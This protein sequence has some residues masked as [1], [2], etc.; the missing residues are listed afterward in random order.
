L[1]KTIQILCFAF[2]IHILFG[3]FTSAYAEEAL[4][5][6]GK[7]QV[8]LVSAYYSPLPNQE[9]YV[10][11]SYEA[12]IRLNGK[13][14]AGADG[15]PVYV[16]MLAAP[17]S[18]PFGTQI[19]IPGLGIGTVHDR[20][21]A[22]LELGN[23]HR[24]DVWMG[25]GDDGR[26]RALS[27]GMRTV[28][29]KIY[30]AGT[31]SG[32]T[33]AFENFTPPS[34]PPPSS[35]PSS[36]IVQSLSLGSTGEAVQKLQTMLSDIGIYN[37][38]ISG[39]FDK[40]TQKA[41]IAFQKNKN[42]IT[43][44]S[45]NGAGVFGPKTRNA[46]SQAIS[47]YQ[48]K[49]MTS[50]EI[51]FPVGMEKGKEGSEIKRLQLF[52]SDLGFFQGSITGTFGPVTEKAV[53]SFQI[54]YGVIASEREQGAGIIGPKTQNTIIQEI[55]KKIARS[56]ASVSNALVSASVEKR[57]EAKKER[58]PAVINETKILEAEFTPKRSRQRT[59]SI[60]EIANKLKEE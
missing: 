43:N 15:T 28:E 22:I 48:Q 6:E 25:Y 54:A 51:L 36:P 39:N 41:L 20:G 26:K 21:G 24:I 60:E 44:E 35:S 52:L 10:R 29:G 14:V 45:D 34:S 31:A 23:V 17:K 18:Y 16:G 38:E 58:S 9:A 46:L 40:T 57:T 4:P 19:F 13:G 2:A 59:S 56:S 47:E 5:N 11:G 7:T 30:T 1:K 3:N 8:F 27:W 33:I 32:Q 37:D 49:M 12:D 42:I 55:T 53:L 50:A